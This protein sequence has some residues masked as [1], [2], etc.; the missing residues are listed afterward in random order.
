[1]HTKVIQRLKEMESSYKGGK[2]GE[3]GGSP[4]AHKNHVT[5]NTYNAYEQ[6]EKTHQYWYLELCR[7]P[8]LKLTQKFHFEYLQFTYS[9]M[10][11]L[12]W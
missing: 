4:T 6:F 10:F 5:V 7:L 11:I 3:A 12:L 1:M 9:L 8:Y 2:T